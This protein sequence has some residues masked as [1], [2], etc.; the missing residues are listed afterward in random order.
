MEGVI[1]IWLSIIW[2]STSSIVLKEIVHVLPTGIVSTS[3]DKDQEKKI[4]K[5]DLSVSL[6]YKT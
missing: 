5:E 3:G 2:I 1:L 4:A 6:L